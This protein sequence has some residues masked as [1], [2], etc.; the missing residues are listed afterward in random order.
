MAWQHGILA[1]GDGARREA[2]V[3]VGVAAV[4][5]GVAVGQRLA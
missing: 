1:G 4:A 3:L 2:T 5:L